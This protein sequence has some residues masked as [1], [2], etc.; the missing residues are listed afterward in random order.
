MCG[1]LIVVVSLVAEPGF[2]A[3]GFRVVVPRLESTGSIVVVHGLSCSTLRGIFPDKGLNLC[4]PQ[5]Q[6]DSLPLSHLGSPI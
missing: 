1:L 6:A 4:L 2:R 5:W 3:R